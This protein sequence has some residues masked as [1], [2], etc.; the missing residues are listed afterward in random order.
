MGH[1]LDLSLTQ[2]LCQRLH[3]GFIEVKGGKSVGLP[4]PQITHKKS[5]DTV[6]EGKKNKDIRRV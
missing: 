6:D 2:A 5:E 4:K 3:C 1:I